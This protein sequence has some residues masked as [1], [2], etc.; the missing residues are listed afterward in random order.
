M[1]VGIRLPCFRLAAALQRVLDSGT[2]AFLVER[3]GRRIVEGTDAA[4]AL[5][6]R[7]GMALREAVRLAPRAAVALDDPVRAVRAWM[8]VLDIL[9]ALPELTLEDLTAA[10][11]YAASHPTEIE[12]CSSST[13]PLRR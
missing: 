9:R 7:P 4:A 1:T 6:I 5:G 3:S 13:R 8:R 11:E 10:W 12:R 2:S